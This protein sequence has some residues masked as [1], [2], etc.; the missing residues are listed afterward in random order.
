[1]EL[2]AAG[3]RRFPD[4]PR[5]DAGAEDSSML[6]IRD[7]L[8]SQLQKD[9]LRQE[10]ILAELARIER[11]MALRA[12]DAERASPR[13]PFSVVKLEEMP[14]SREAFGPA[15][16]IVAADVDNDMEEKKDSATSLQASNLIHRKKPAEY[17]VRECLK[18]SC[19]AGNAAGRRQNAA[20]DETKLQ[21]P[22][23][24]N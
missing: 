24:V 19:G 21:E 9:R 15:D 3:D 7:A 5:H 4:P 12:A 16:L 14:R 22:T 20:L 2:F 8:L 1:M 13:A 11:A 6:V 10:I 17:L 18:T 23:E